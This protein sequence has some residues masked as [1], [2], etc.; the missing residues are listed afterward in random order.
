MWVTSTKCS[1]DCFSTGYRL[2]SVCF[3]SPLC[4]SCCLSFHQ[5]KSIWTQRRLT[6][7]WIGHC[8]L[9]RSNSN[10]SWG[11]QIFT[12]DSTETTARLLALWEASPPWTPSSPGPR[13]PRKHFACSCLSSLHCLF[14]GCLTQSSSSLSRWTPHSG[15]RSHSFPAL[16]WSSSS[17]SLRL[18]HQ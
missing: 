1:S 10:G 2:R 16:L 11:L 8:I 15:G 14:Y 7:L 13:R 4:Q 17:S 6:P 9:I 12:A 3:T 18:F 5:A